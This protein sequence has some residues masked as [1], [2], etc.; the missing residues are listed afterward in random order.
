M[1]NLAVLCIAVLASS[2]WAQTY[3]KPHV[4][5]DGTYTEGHY[6]SNPNNTERD[7]YGTKG[8]Y[9]P[10]TGQD[11]TRTPREDRPNYSPPTPTYGQQCGYTSSGR[12]VCR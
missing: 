8:N 4:N 7:N 2:A 12:Y 6:R 5:R 1:K 9:N 11:G 10:Y 3:V